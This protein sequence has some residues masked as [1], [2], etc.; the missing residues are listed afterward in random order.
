[1]RLFTLFAL[2]CLIA[3]PARAEEAPLRSVISQLLASQKSAFEKTGGKFGT[4]GDMLIEQAGSYYAVTLPDIT[5]VHPDEAHTA[6]GLIAMNASR[7]DAKNWNITM[8]LPTPIV[9]KTNT[10]DVQSELMLG[11]QQFTGLWDVD[12]KNFTTLKTLYQDARLVFP[13][14]TPTIPFSSATA[15][16]IGYGYNLSEKGNQKADLSLR[17]GLEKLSAQNLNQ[18]YARLFPGDATFNIDVKDFPQ[19]KIADLQKIMTSPE[20]L[21]GLPPLLASAG[22]QVVV[23]KLQLK[24]AGYDLTANGT[25]TPSSTAPLG[26]T[27]RMVLNATNMDQIIQGLNDLSSTLSKEGKVKIQAARAAL[28]LMKAMGQPNGA[29]QKYDVELKEDGAIMMNGTDFTALVSGLAKT[30]DTQ[31]AR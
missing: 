3:L 19:D 20:G 5:L 10:G 18:A 26:Y 4:T 13:R 16:K 2:T 15:G 7:A 27:G 14:P 11:R 22:S 1:M 28:T 17:F 24:N 21:S 30:A 6:L 25:L 12:Y 9:T 29:A 31:S 23:H 8:A